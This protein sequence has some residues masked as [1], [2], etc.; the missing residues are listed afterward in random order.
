[1]DVDWARLVGLVQG[2]R[3]AAGHFFIIISTVDLVIIY[4][5]FTIEYLCHR[6]RW[7]RVAGRLNTVT[8]TA[9]LIKTDAMGVELIRKYN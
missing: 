8:E 5:I 4:G 3:T 2:Y 9:I 7:A 6:C 1:M